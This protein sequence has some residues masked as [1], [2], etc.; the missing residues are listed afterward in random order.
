MKI[1]NL[2]LLFLGDIV[3]KP[4]RR[5]V[6]HFVPLIRE[7][8]KIDL[9]F[10]NA[11]NLSGGKG[12][13]FEI[14]EEMLAAG[15]D[16]FTSGNHIWANKDIIPYIKDDSVKILRPANYPAGTPGKGSVTIN[17]QGIKITLANLMGRVFIPQLFADPFRAAKD[18]VSEHKDTI[19]II[20]FHAEATSEKI[21][22]AHYLDGEVAAVVGTH[23]HV[24]TADERILPG[25]TGFITDL[26]MCGP[27]D[28]V[29]G[30]EKNIIIAEFLTALPQ[31]HKVAVGDSALSA[32]ILEID[33]QSRKTISIKRVFETLKEN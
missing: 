29:I 10:A 23:T 31:S 1:E 4:G 24:Q 17:Y 16:Y 7:A 11:E 3:G 15:I 5:A 20:D 25:G 30:V 14:Y 27:V 26:G 18:I 19:I 2:K 32:C 22:L 13:T 21:A 8:E 33:Q 12:I 28:S 9:V 6:A